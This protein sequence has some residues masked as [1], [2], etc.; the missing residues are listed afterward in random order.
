[1]IAVMGLRL[2][3]ASLA[4]SLLTSATMDGP[5]SYGHPQRPVRVATGP[6]LRPFPEQAQADVPPTIAHGYAKL[7]AQQFGLSFVEQPHD[8][9]LAAIAAV[10]TRQADLV[11]VQGAA[12]DLHLPCASLIQSRPFRGGDTVLAGP[13]GAPLP[14]DAS[15]LNGLKLAAVEGDPYPDWLAARH[16]QAQVL[17][18]PNMHAALALVDA[19]TADAAIG[20]SRPPH[21]RRSSC[22][23]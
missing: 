4:A 16:S 7:M 2:A 22:L 5:Q 21:P 1:V 11:L 14:H 10:C 20:P 13:L 15:G 3:I 23:I 18:T 17:A 8:N 6:I 12:T 9:T 19:G